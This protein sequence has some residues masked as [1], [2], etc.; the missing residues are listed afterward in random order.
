MKI[1]KSRRLSSHLGIFASLFA[2]ALFATV[3]F[4]INSTKPASAATVPESC[5]SF[6]PGTGTITDYDPTGTDPLCLKDL[7]IPAT[8]GGVDVTHIGSGAFSSKLLTNVSVPDS[9]QTIETASFY[10]NNI[11]TLHL[12]SQLTSIG[13]SAFSYN[14]LTSINIPSHVV[15]IGYNAFSSNNLTSVILPESVESVSCD[16]FGSNNI[17]TVVMGNKINGVTCP[18]FSGSPITSLTIGT[19]DYTGPANNSL[20]N[21]GFAGLPVENLVLGNSINLISNGVFSGLLIQKITI[22]EHVAELSNGALGSSTIQEITFDGDTTI[23]GDPFVGVT[24]TT[25]QYIRLLTSDPSNP[26]GYTDSANTYIVNPAAITVKY[27]DSHGNTLSPELYQTGA[28]LTDYTVTANPTADFSLYYRSGQSLS[29]AASA[30][31]G[32]Q[33]PAAQ[34]ISLLPGANTVTFVYYTPAE[35]VAMNTLEAPKTGLEHAVSPILYVIVAFV[36]V[37]AVAILVIKRHKT[38]K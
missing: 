27:V 9:V 13:D 32:Y 21:G 12:G 16:A 38:S 18:W 11:T 22:P 17:N 23:T 37:S 29:Y 31:E 34:S 2:L 6:T 4:T 26:Y 5:F 3:A 15:T 24:Y 10:Q 14:Q 7:D 25:G 20:T 30:I 19:T 36:G 35:I 1:V 33:T 28:T 8:I